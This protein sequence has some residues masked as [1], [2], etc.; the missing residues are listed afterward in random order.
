MKLLL[1]AL[2]LLVAACGTRGDRWDDSLDPVGPVAAGVHLVWFVPTTGRVVAIDLAGEEVRSFPAGAV[3]R[4]LAA[5]DGGVAVLGGTG[6]RP[7]LRRLALP[8]G[9]ATSLAVPA[10]Y[11]RIAVAP[12]GTKAVLYFDPAAPPAPG[13]PAARNFNEIAVVDFATGAVRAVSLDTESLAPRGVV[14]SPAG[15][16]AAVVLDA[17]VALVDL[18]DPAVHVRIPL[19]LAGGE[20]LAPVEALFSPDAAFLYV[21]AAAARDVLA[22]EVRREAGELGGSVNFLFVPGADLVDD[23]VV[24]AGPGFERSVAA[25]FRSGATGIAALL[26]ATGDASKGHL[27]P[28]SRRAS[29]IEDLGGG[30]LL[31]YP[32]TSASGANVPRAVAAWEPLTDRLDEDLLPGPS[33]RPPRFAPGAGFFFHDAVSLPGTGATP[34]LTV[35]T[36]DDTGARLRV[37]LTSVGLAHEPGPSAV[38]PDTGLLLLGVDV[39]RKDSGAARDEDGGDASELT[40]SLVAVGPAGGAELPIGGIALDDPIVDLG[41]AG[42][43]LWARHDTASGDVTV[44]PLADLRRSAARRYDGLFLAGALEE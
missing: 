40:G 21:R 32:A 31:L 8:S 16:L 24:P 23:I 26:D 14:F 12:G 36:V 3:P 41:L 30:R 39:L 25:V 22:I 11:D 35:V 4:A 13:S 15:D 37:Q 44:L 2:A 38:A 19:K 7:G 33:S 17:A 42:A 18:A 27:A 10:A 20:E 6:H 43:Y 1:L 9:D 29:G 5:V 34:A 28:L